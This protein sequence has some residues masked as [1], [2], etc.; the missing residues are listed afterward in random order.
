MRLLE[1]TE[2]VT[3]VVLPLQRVLFRSA[4][5]CDVRP[6]RAG[7]HAEGGCDSRTTVE[8]FKL[9]VRFHCAHW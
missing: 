4:G 7:R 1:L 5:G 8:R 6:R 2:H 9:L 3:R